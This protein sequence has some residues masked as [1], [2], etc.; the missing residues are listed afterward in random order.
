MLKRFRYHILVFFSVIGPGFVTAM[1]D[2]DSGGILTYSQAGAR[3]GYL[4]LWTL[5]PI[6]ILLVVT[7]EMNSRMGAVTG[8]GLSDLIREEFGLRTTFLVMSL[9]VLTNLTNIM[10][11]FAGIATSLELFGLS[12]LISVPIGAA[13]VWLLVVKGTY[14]SV[15]KIFLGACVVYAAYI[16]SAFLIEPNWKA[17]AVGSIHPVLMLDPGYITM[18][19]GMVGTSIAPWMQFY[20]QAAVVEK[21]VTEKDYSE[22]RVE[23]IVGCIAMSVIAFFII[24]SCAGAIWSNGP[25][26]INTAADAAVALKPFGKYAFVLFSAGL[27]NASLFAASILP[28]STAYSVCE[29]LG[30]ESGVNKRFGEAPIFYWLYTLLIVIGAGVV[31]LPHFPLVRMILLSQ[32]LNGVLLPVI[33][34]FMILLVNRGE[35]MGKWTNSRMYNAIAW[36]SVAILVGLTLALVSI[37][38]REMLA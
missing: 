38:I 25:R 31:L 34:V 33:L 17:A 16:V 5:L 4:P 2:N 29:G 24:V 13:A 35:L 12:R 37:T 3:Y 10:A 32:V 21:G 28:L 26:D 20:L 6:T 8:K 22:S 7:Q 18:L 11:E 23:V 36:S 9:L 15:E 27:F 14:R 1:V 19:I 30:F